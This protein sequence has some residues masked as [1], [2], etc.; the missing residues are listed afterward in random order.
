MG[1]F[2]PKSAGHFKS[3][4]KEGLIA[5]GISMAGVYSRGRDY[6]SQEADRNSIFRFMTFTSEP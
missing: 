4:I 2:S 3:V 5:D 6:L 1:T